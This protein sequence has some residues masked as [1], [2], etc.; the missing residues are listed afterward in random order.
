MYL[1]NRL[2]LRFFDHPSTALRTASISAST[3]IGFAQTSTTSVGSFKMLPVVIQT[4][5]SS[6]SISPSASETHFIIRVYHSIHLV[7]CLRTAFAFPNRRLQDHERVER[8]DAAIAANVPSRV[9]RAAA[10]YDL[11]RDHGVRGGKCMRFLRGRGA[12]D[13]FGLEWIELDFTPAAFFVIVDARID[14]AAVHSG[15]PVV[16]LRF[17][18]VV[19]VDVELPLPT[20]GQCVVVAVLDDVVVID[21]VASASTGEIEALSVALH[22]VAGDDVVA[23]RIIQPDAALVVRVNGVARERVVARRR[24]VDAVLAVRV[25]GVVRERVVARRKQPDAAVVPI[26]IIPGDVT[27]IYIVET[28][29]SH[30]VVCC[31]PYYKPADVHTIR[32]HPKDRST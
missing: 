5:R 11:E 7:R 13:W 19:L 15:A 17:N 20:A 1:R 27:A 4:I 14:R 16:V 28:N 10:G 2:T 32:S 31:T 26:Y 9:G 30:I 21:V 25:H 6:A 29:S 12:W 8:C 23:A 18:R 3:S 24:Q 22:Q